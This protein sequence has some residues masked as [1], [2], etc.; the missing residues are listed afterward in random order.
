MGWI[1]F[2]WTLFVRLAKFANSMRDSVQD[3]TASQQKFLHLIALLEFPSSSNVFL[4]DRVTFHSVNLL[5]AGRGVR[6]ARLLPFRMR[7]VKMIL[8]PF[9]SSF[10]FSNCTSTNRFPQ[11]AHAFSAIIG[12]CCGPRSPTRAFL[13]KRINFRQISMPR[14]TLQ[15]L[16][17]ISVYNWKPIV[18][19]LMRVC[20]RRR[21]RVEL[22]T[23]ET[24][25]YIGPR[26]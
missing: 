15:E 17:C 7:Y 25:M 18:R 21:V 9:L 12:H 6:A 1:V 10:P 20:V 4:L 13:S 23:R 24:R 8:L 16:C 2:R 26:R 19:N 22:E 5:F 11:L 14:R 3:V